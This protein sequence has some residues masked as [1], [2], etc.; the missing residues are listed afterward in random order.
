VLVVSPVVVPGMDGSLS[1]RFCGELLAVTTAGD[2]SGHAEGCPV[3]DVYA[4]I[5]AGRLRDARS[6]WDLLAAEQR[7]V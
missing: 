5:S 7:R 6:K 3:L 1:C 2:I 4:D